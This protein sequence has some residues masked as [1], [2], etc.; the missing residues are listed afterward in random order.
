M[1]GRPQ[2]KS[3][4]TTL[5]RDAWN[6]AALSPKLPVQLE[7]LLSKQGFTVIHVEPIPILIRS[8]RLGN[9]A[10][11]TLKW[12]AHY[13]QEQGAVTKEEAVTWLADL[14]RLGEKDEFFFCVNRFLF[15]AVKL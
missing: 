3:R 1:I 5:R 8:Y 4:T 14:F 2:K 15:T 7:P 13:A 6:D 12:V 11:D 10:V 9:F